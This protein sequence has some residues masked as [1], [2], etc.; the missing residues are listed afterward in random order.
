M[1]TDGELVL[2]NPSRVA[3][4]PL[5]GARLFD[6]TVQALPALSDG[7]FFA[8]DTKTLKCFRVGKR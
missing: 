4:Q 7:L 5:A 1:K 8:R 2:V 3:Y 6:D